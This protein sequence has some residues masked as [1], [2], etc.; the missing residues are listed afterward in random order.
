MRDLRSALAYLITGNKSCE[1]VHAARHGAEAGASLINV[2][3][4]QSAFAP[5]EQHDELLADLMPF[6]PARFPQPHLDRFLH[7]HQTVRDTEQ[8]SLLFADKRDLPFQ[9]FENE[10]TWIAAFKRRLYFDA[11]KPVVASQDGSGSVVP[12]VRWLALLPYEYS[13]LFMKMLDGLLDD[14]EMRKLREV[15]N[16]R[17]SAFGWC[18]RKCARRKTQC[19][20]QC[21]N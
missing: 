21:L 2:A 5:V 11:G 6:D 8:R 10:T 19:E 9:R 13:K 7:F 1:Q 20:S 15:V 18:H 14:E 4:W 3:Y 16:P 12:K 17:H